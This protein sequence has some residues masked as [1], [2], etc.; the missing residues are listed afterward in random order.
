MSRGELSVARRPRRQSPRAAGRRAGAAGRSGGSR[1]LRARG[2]LGCAAGAGRRR[3]RGSPRHGLTKGGPPGPA[4]RPYGPEVALVAGPG[5]WTS[6]EGE[7]ALPAWAPAPGRSP[8]ASKPPA[9]GLRAPADS[10]PAARRRTHRRAGESALPAALRSSAGSKPTSA[11]KSSGLVRPWPRLS[12]V[13]PRRQ[14]PG[15]APP[16]LRAA[17]PVG[18]QRPSF[19]GSAPLPGT[20]PLPPGPAP[21]RARPPPHPCPLTL[22]RPPRPEAAADGRARRRPP[23]P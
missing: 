19:L 5:P 21:S 17:L 2:A 11:S 20:L 16:S 6:G 9:Q 7:E 15:V 14:S 8:R 4:P 23:R 1:L 22:R 3:R 18:P 10:G 13:G 12:S